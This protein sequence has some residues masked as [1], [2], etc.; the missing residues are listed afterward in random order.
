MGR[1]RR[2]A[3][4]LVLAALGATPPAGAGAFLDPLDSPAEP[5]PLAV[6]RPLTAVTLA[7]SRLV[8]VGQ[9]GHILRSDDAGASWAQ[10][11]SP[12]SSDLTSVFF[13]TPGLGWAAGHDAVVLRTRDG[14]TTWERL[15]DGR[16][17]RRLL[18]DHAAASGA[19]GR[20]P[21]AGATPDA[22]GPIL[23]LW[24]DDGRTGWAV[25]AFNLLLRT[26]DGGRTWQ[27]WHDRVEN[28]RGL[29]LYAIRR[30][31]EGLFVAGE[32]GLLLRLDP[33]RQRFVA[34]RVPAQGSFFGLG[35]SAPTVLAYGLRGQAVRSGDGG[36]TWR[37]VPTGLDQSLVGGTTLPDGRL[38][39]VAL[40]G[41]VLLSADEGRT[42]RP[43]RRAGARPA[44]AVAPSGAGALLLVGPAGARVEGLP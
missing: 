17:L 40:S 10:A 28:P 18:A 38:V 44:S 20:G 24:F 30:V 4:W 14:G 5:S 13:A 27:A 7:G 15:L 6:R 32:Q 33:I 2:T 29:H 35:G 26:G 8:A 1:A 16:G 22:D 39:L 42:F 3:A 34:L 11:A 23:D 19:A 43:L 25:G 37:P 31:G 36:A 21:A 9:R 41:E 12:V